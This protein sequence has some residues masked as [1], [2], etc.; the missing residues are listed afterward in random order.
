MAPTVR[1]V[2]SAEG[3][4]GRS[5]HTNICRV[6]ETYEYSLLMQFFE[7]ILSSLRLKYII[8]CDAKSVISH[9][10]YGSILTYET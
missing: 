4:L 10:N 7:T 1:R 3:A 5:L 2:D 8:R 6:L 9:A